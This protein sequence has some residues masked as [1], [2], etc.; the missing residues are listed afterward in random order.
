MA[1]DSPHGT[2]SIDD[3]LGHA[4]WVRGLARSLVQDDATADDLV[5]DVWT[6]ALHTPP[7]DR[8]SARPWLATVLRNLARDRGRTGGRRRRREERVARSEAVADTATV[9]ARAE[10]HRRLVEAVMALPEPYR[11]TV[12][13]RYFE[14]LPPRTVAERMDVPVETVRTRTRRALERLRTRLD[15]GEGGRDAWRAALLPIALGPVADTPSGD[16]S[17]PFKL[18]VVT[19]LLVAVPGAAYL[20]SLDAPPAA[21][22]VAAADEEPVPAPPRD[23]GERRDGLDPVP[24]PLV[25]DEGPRTGPEEGDRERTHRYDPFAEAREKEEKLWEAPAEMFENGALSLSVAFEPEVPVVDEPFHVVTTFRN[26]GTGPVRFHVREFAGA[27]PFPSI[28]FRDDQGRPYRVAPMMFQSMWKTGLQGAVVQLEP[29][30]THDVRSSVTE[31]VPVAEND[32]ED[33]SRYGTSQKRH[34]IQPGTYAVS[35]RLHKEQPTVPWGKEGFEST[36]R[37]LPGL[38]TGEV[39]AEPVSVRIVTAREPRLTWTVPDTLRVGEQPTATLVFE[40]P[41][42]EAR[43]LPG[44]FVVR[45]TEKGGPPH[46]A[47]IEITPDGVR[48]AQPEEETSLRLEAGERR[49]VEIRLD[50]LDWTA[51]PRGRAALN[52]SP[53][54]HG[55]EYGMT[56]VTGG[57]DAEDGRPTYSSN[58]SEYV[59]EPAPLLEGVSLTLDPARLFDA[60]PSLTVHLRNESAETLRLPPELAAHLR[61]ALHQ[62]RS[63]HAPPRLVTGSVGAP[64]ELRPGEVWSGE[65]AVEPDWRDTRTTAGDYELV[66][67]WA[68]ADP[69][70][71]DE[72]TLGRLVAEPARVRVPE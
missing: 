35:V 66:A 44:P 14:G 48:A 1:P 41:T 54:P 60:T 9:V 6:Q 58:S 15:T 46:A 68:N 72:W 64:I 69:G 47:W 5:Q 16:R 45:R 28:E 57:R 13:L 18:I 33:E 30:E 61:L 63:R 21:D 67:S 38:W 2:L 50:R 17:M 39:V 40:N 71:D 59:A 31:L 23:R 10:T 7:D 19:A 42:N 36:S 37:E 32:P 62:E 11:E 4:G 43:V 3:L 12:L 20:L 26:T 70:A 22:P 53:W 25:P 29:G 56:W 34:P 27:L 52:R 55:R 49:T 51:Q 8:G 24:A 65:L